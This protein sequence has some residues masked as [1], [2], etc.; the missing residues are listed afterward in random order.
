MRIQAT[1][2]IATFATSSI[3]A[4]CGLFYFGDGRLIDRGYFSTPQYELDLG[5]VD[6]TRVSTY[7]YRLVGLPEVRMTIGFEIIET[8]P[9]SSIGQRPS[10][11]SVVRLEVKNSDNGT[12]VSEYGSLDS[13]V[14][15]YGEHDPVSFLYRRGE[16]KEIRLEN[17]M[18]HYQWV[19]VKT[20]GGWGT[21]FTPTR[22][23]TYTLTLNVVEAQQPP[24]RPTRLLLRGGGWMS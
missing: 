3:T 14:W 5:P 15:S 17:G 1:I 16:E 24:Q 9:N 21:Y 11:P 12:A 19:G 23:T 20:D 2:I 4:G 10:H 8:K 18:T 22:M 6:L 7:T 13:W